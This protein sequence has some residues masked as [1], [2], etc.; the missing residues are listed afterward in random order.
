MGRR[1]AL[2]FSDVAS[3]AVA[4][5]FKTFLGIIA[6]AT[7]GHR[8]RL[9][10][11]ELGPA[12]A[13]AQDINYSARINRTD[14]STAGTAGASPTPAKVD[15]NAEASVMTAGRDYSA[16]PTAFETEPIWEVGLNSRGSFFKEWLPS[17]APRWGP[18]ETLAL[19]IAPRTGTAVNLSGTLIWEE[20]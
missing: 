8:G 12:D 18:S 1:Y 14:Q 4:D 2:T 3:G 20:D 9:V 17:D 5:T 16:E 6:G 11:L 15:P 10:S 7:A 19:L 13:T